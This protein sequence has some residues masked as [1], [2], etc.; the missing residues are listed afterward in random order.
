MLASS[1]KNLRFV[2]VA[3]NTRRLFG[4]RG[5]AARQDV[6]VTEDVDEPLGGDG[7]REACVANKKGKK[8][9]VGQKRREGA[10]SVS[11]DKVKRNSQT[12]NGSNC[13][14]GSKK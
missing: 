11:G 9:E 14:A 4:S 12:L 10:P 3:A 8:Q 1:Q 2:D 7:N 6:L 13:R 5:G